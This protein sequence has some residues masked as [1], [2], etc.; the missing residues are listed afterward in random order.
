MRGCGERIAAGRSGHAAFARPIGVAGVAVLLA[1]TIGVPVHA[2]GP[3]ALGPP[4]DPARLT[5][6]DEYLARAQDEIGIPGLAVV[7]V[8]GDQTV[9]LYSAGRADEGRSLSPQTPFMLAST[10]KAFTALAVIQQVEAGALDLDAT[11]QHYLPWFSL[12]DPA[13]AAQIT[14]RQLLLHTSGLSP[15]SGQAYHDSDDQDAGALERTI[16]ALAV[17]ELVSAPGA[18]HHYSNTNSDIL[19]L[20][21]QTISGE[22]LSQYVEEKIFAPLDMLH[23]HGTLEAAR[24]DGLS[25][26]YYHWFG[27][28]W[29]P[30][31]IP[32][33]RAGEPSATTF[34]SAED[35][36]HWIV[37]HLNGGRYGETQVVSEAGMAALH[38]AGVQS[39]DFHGYAFGWG[40]RPLWEALDPVAPLADGFYQLPILVEH[41]GEWANG[42]SY[43]GLVPAE[44]WGFG[45][46]VNA[47]DF[48]EGSRFSLLEQ[49]VLRILEGREPFDWIPGEAPLDQ[50][51]KLIAGLLLLA[52]V[53]SFVWWVR[54]LRSLAR[55]ATGARSRRV[56]AAGAI[57]LV[58]DAFVL[59]LYLVIAPDHA[60][61]TIAVLFRETPDLAVFALPTL[62]LAILWGPIRTI[63]W[64]SRLLGF[65]RGGPSA[66]PPRP[67][68][69]DAAVSQ[70]S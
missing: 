25:A 56:I 66:S 41:S 43:V 62:A 4:I 1:M 37:A 45:L 23:S 46:L 35:L 60:D 68:A 28:A 19:G 70:S 54:R 42:H 64:A 29:Q 24:A 38:T 58:L 49:N 48:A 52:E 7:V 51:A 11:V 3:T 40:S 12:A 59:V 6:L 53:V 5:A 34:V 55:G 61:S 63:W 8:Q 57:A 67:Q 69:P 50:N 2:A 44:G 9:H 31:A 18:E 22:P 65:R 14:L 30:T 32:L 26:G 15:A 17:S 13:A 16:R 27:L 39:D 21:V 47:W 33:P 10:S 36:G 20:I